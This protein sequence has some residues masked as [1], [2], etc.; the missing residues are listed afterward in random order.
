ML[1]KIVGSSKNRKY[2]EMKTVIRTFRT[3]KF[4]YSADRDLNAAQVILKRATASHVGCNACG[5]GAIG[6]V[7]EATER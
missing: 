3:Y 6:S 7:N 5:V 2:T 4:G 1:T